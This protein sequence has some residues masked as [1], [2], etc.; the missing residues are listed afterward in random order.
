MIGNCVAY[1][2][3]A[4]AQGKPIV[5]INRGVTRADPLLAFKVEDDCG[6]ALSALMQ[7]PDLCFDT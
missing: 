2:R 4:H 5:S 3:A 1:A 6:V 7:T